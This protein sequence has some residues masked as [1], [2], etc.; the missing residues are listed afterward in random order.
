[1]YIDMFHEAKWGKSTKQR[2]LEYY[3]RT[4]KQ[5]IGLRDD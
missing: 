3:V 5:K 4:N 2:R 1:M